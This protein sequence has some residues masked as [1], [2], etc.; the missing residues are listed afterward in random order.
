MAVRDFDGSENFPRRFLFLKIEILGFVDGMK[1]INWLKDSGCKVLNLLTKGSLNHCLHQLRKQPDEHIADIKE[2]VA[3]AVEN[4]IRVNI[5][6]E[7]WSNGMR[8]S[9][10]YVIDM[11]DALKDTAI[12]EGKIEFKVINGCTIENRAAVGKAIPDDVLAE[13]KTCHVLLKGPTTT[14]RKG[15]QWANVESANRLSYF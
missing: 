4:G 5:Y 14:P 6:L 10:Q 8:T 13:I 1:S 11:L 9:K 7:D 2:V 15:D 3:S 12:S